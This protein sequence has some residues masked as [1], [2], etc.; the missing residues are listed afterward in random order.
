MKKEYSTVNGW[1]FGGSVGIEYANG[2]FRLRIGRTYYRHSAS[3]P[4]RQMWIGRRKFWASK[5][6]ND[7]EL[8][9]IKSI[10]VVYHNGHFGQKSFSYFQGY[11]KD[12]AIGKV[13]RDSSV[14]IK[15]AVA[16]EI[17]I[18]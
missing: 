13:K 5:A 2:P 8:E 10:V 7:K 9:A 4:Y 1:G 12:Q 16:R 6:K 18:K 14:K 17:I 11:S 15:W 3:S